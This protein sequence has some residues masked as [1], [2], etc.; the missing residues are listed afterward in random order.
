MPPA[1]TQ[2]V[3]VPIVNPGVHRGPIGPGALSSLDNFIVNPSAPAPPSKPAATPSPQKLARNDVKISDK[4]YGR[5]DPPPPLGD[6]DKVQ[7]EESIPEPEHLQKQREKQESSSSADINESLDAFMAEQ[8]GEGGD[9]EAASASTA[10]SPEETSTPSET[11]PETPP[12]DED[13]AKELESFGKGPKPLR[14]A[15][16]AA[17]KREAKLMQERAQLAA[18]LKE[19]ET[20][21][22]AYKTGAE[23]SEA[24]KAK[25]AE[26]EKAIAE[27]EE[28][29]RILDY[30]KSGEFGEKYQAPLVKAWE[31]ALADVER[32][33]IVDEST[34]TTRKPTDADLK[35]LI[36]TDN[37]AKAGEMAEQLFGKWGAQE[38]MNHRR[39]IRNLD[40]ARQQALQNAA[41]E[42][43]ALLERR[44]AETTQ[45]RQQA[46]AKFNK[47]KQEILTGKF[48]ELLGEVEGDDEG[49]NILRSNLS[50][51]EKLIDANGDPESQ[52]K[53][54]A[55]LHVMAAK[56]PVA[57]RDI[58]R[59]RA[60]LA[61]AQKQLK[62]FQKSTPRGGERST[63]GQFK[64][65]DQS[66]MEAALAGIDALPGRRV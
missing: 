20:N 30:T 37:P 6:Y 52:I 59:L 7:E 23:A 27:R 33:E 50:K 18:K 49:N 66:P 57:L 63:N 39:T 13:I 61:D 15:F 25:F 44:T 22:E 36:W 31:T 45:Q 32:M 17:R 24:H 60:E 38:A 12:S 64:N 62:G 1:P 14:K 26:Y 65:A 21:L 34:G 53:A 9:D 28:Q 8:G 19:H 48:K 46:F 58:K 11:S 40:A 5:A 42:S 47:A 35:K 2:E 4:T 43:K 3:P 16:E 54:A 55:E 56:L 51:F 10:A 41:T 29:I